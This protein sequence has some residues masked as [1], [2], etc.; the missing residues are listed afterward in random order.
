MHFVQTKS[1]IHR[2]PVYYYNKKEVK[3]RYHFR[4]FTDKLIAKWSGESKFTINIHI[5]RPGIHLMV[6]S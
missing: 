3:G 4:V 1:I 2:T 5:S 6:T